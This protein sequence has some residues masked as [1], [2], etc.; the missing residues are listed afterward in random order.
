MLLKQC[1]RYVSKFGKLSN[2]HKT[3]KGQFSFQ[4][5][6]MFKQLH[7]CTQFAFQQGNAQNPSIWALIVHEP[8][9]SRCTSQIQKRQRSQRSNCQKAREFQR[10]IYCF[11]DYAK[12]L[13]CVDHS[14]LWKILKEMGILDH[15]NCLLRNLN[16]A[17]VIVR[18][19]TVDW[20]QIGKGHGCILASC[21]LDLYAEYIM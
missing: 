21:L 11:I 4:S 18:H 5:Q 14:K 9:I 19:G 12:A 8:R 15:F 16:V 7:N 1:T 13:D 17:T 3:G 20:F 2:D 10:N 6:R